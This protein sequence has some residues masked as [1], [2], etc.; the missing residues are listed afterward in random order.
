MNKDKIDN[1]YT[2]TITIHYYYHSLFIL[3]FHFFVD[4]MKNNLINVQIIKIKPQRQK[5]KLPIKIFS[6]FVSMPFEKS[7]FQ[8]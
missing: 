4:F 5:K 1:I 7:I 8:I 3:T 6:C 2:L